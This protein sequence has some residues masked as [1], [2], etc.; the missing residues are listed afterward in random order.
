[1]KEYVILDLEWTSWRG[2]YFGKNLFFQKRKTWQKKEIIQIGAIKF[3]KNYKII[4]RLNLY[5]KPKFNPILS[6]YIKN[7]TRITQEK[8]EKKGITFIKSYKIFKK[9]CKE[10]KIFSNGFDDLIMKTN[11]H[12]NNLRDKKLKIKNIKKILN[13]KYKIPKE[14]LPSPIIHTFFGYKLKKNKMHNAIYD[15]RN[16]LKTFKKIKFIL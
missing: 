1:M 12:Y 9:F 6:D 15:C 4:D 14:F 8:L 2:N 7:L 10:A 5:V 11:L 13:K 16:V 3:D